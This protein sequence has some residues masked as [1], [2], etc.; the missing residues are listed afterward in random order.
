MDYLLTTD[1]ITE[2]ADDGES[3]SPVIGRQ[4]PATT[5]GGGNGTWYPMPKSCWETKCAICSAPLAKIHTR[6][7]RYCGR[8]ECPSSRNALDWQ[9]APTDG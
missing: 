3:L 1:G 8:D 2:V 5:V 6:S 4:K 9:K 7:A